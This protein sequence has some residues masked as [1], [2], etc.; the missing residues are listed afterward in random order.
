MVSEPGS[1]VLLA[2]VLM[3]F[4]FSAGVSRPSVKLGRFNLTRIRNR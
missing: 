4:L 1:L 2:L 3:V